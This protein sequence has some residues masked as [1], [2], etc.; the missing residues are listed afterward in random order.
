MH[1]IAPGVV[2]WTTFH[3]GI[4]GEVSSYYVVDGAALVDP[5]APEGG[6][7]ALAEAYGPPGVVLLTNRHHY[8]HT[9]DV[10][11]RFGATVH[12]HESGLYEFEHDRQVEGFAFG[13]ELPGGA[14]AFELGA[15]CP[16]ETAIWFAGVGALAFADGLVRI[17]PDA[18]PGFVPDGLIG[19]DPAAVKDGL[20]AG[21]ARLA[22][23]DPSLLL[24]AHGNPIIGAGGDVL[25]RAAVRA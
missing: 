16:D 18:E 21:F 13:D 1:E 12:C 5:R 4:H 20:R 7:D 14:T 11:A 15:I 2:H 22:E 19:D 8:R 6:F 3:E 17:P 23:L 24:L 9:N 10:V 25:R